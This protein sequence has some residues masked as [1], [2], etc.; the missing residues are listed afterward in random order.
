MIVSCY[1]REAKE[2]I[3]R[4]LYFEVGNIVFELVNTIFP[5]SFIFILMEHRC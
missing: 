1:H 2:S 5:Y 3:G 4:I